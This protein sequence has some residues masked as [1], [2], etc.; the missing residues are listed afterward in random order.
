ME[1]VRLGRTN[2][3]VTRLGWGGIPI[4]R[5]SEDEAVAVVRPSLKWASTFS[6]R[7]AATPR[8]S[9]GSGWR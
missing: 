7:R 5:V 4:Q 9:T 8:A 2:L 1:K 3:S 6:I